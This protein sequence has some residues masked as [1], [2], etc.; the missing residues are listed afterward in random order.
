MKKEFIPYN[1]AI[2]LKEL[3][4]DGKCFGG[5]NNEGNLY[6][7]GNNMDACPV[8]L[9]QQAFRFFREKYYIFCSIN[10]CHIGSDEWVYVYNI[11]YLPKD[12]WDAKKRC[13][14]F[15]YIE[16]YIDS[17]SMYYGG[18]DTYEQAELAC[19]EKMIEIV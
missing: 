9:F 15:I 16:S 14:H 1:L 11:N 19:L 6:Y 3:G 18:W 5:Y 10:I 2:K 12:H 8:P 4:F 7:S 17:G 13:N